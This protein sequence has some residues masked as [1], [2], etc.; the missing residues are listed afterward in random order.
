LGSFRAGASMV[1]NLFSFF[2]L[3]IV[4]AS[5]LAKA[6][7]TMTKYIA[8]E[9]FS[10]ARSFFEDLDPS[11]Q[12]EMSTFLYGVSLEKSG[13]LQEAI[14]VYKKILKK[15]KLKSSQLLKS[16]KSKEDVILTET[17]ILLEVYERLSICYGQ[18]ALREKDQRK[19]KEYER[20]FNVTYTVSEKIRP[21]SLPT[22]HPL[23]K[24]KSDLDQDKR[25]IFR[26]NFSGFISLTS[27]QDRSTFKQLGGRQKINLLL[28]S[29]SSCTGL[30]F[31]YR[32]ILREVSFDACYLK[33]EAVQ[34]S[35]NSSVSLTQRSIPV[36]GFL[37]QPQVLS[38]VIADELLLGLSI[39]VAFRKY[40]TSA[41]NG[42]FQYSRDTH[43][44]VG[45][46]SVVKYEVSAFFLKFF[47]GKIFSDQSSFFQLSSGVQF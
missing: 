3:F 27:W 43:A 40:E 36:S 45:F 6:Q 18:L 19:K 13:Q 8:N 21:D 23:E 7:D 39:P 16:L 12:D 22:K 38:R 31:T 20:L 14:L 46:A 34:T 17:G 4:C 26:T 9:K 47:Y 29:R 10:E 25:L 24:V 42:F 37:F 30:G 15:N 1:L 11:Q 2:I 32:N 35:T 5:A 41:P 28:T 44:R 33:G